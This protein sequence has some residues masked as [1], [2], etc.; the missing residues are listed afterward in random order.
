MQ[1]ISSGG[2]EVQ[3]TK[4]PDCGGSA[5]PSAKDVKKSLNKYSLLLAPGLLGG[6]LAYVVYP[7]LDQGLLATFGVCALFLPMVL[8]LR[9][10]VRKRLSED[11]GRLRTAYVCSSLALAMLALLL[12]LNGWLDRSPRSLVRTTVVRK[13]FTNGRSVT[14]YL[15]TVSSWRSGRS[16]EDFNVDSRTFSRAA[17]GKTVTVELHQGFFGLPWSGNI[18]PQ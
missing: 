1:T 7:P 10:I 16:E 5:F 18:S 14:K 3:L 11:A 15:L 2:I 9:S 4:P 13:T 8:R 17:V 6:L 12:L